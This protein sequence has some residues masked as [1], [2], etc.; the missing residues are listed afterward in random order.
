MEEALKATDYCCRKNHLY[1]RVKARQ[2]K[3]IETVKAGTRDVLQEIT[4]EA[5]ADEDEDV[6]SLSPSPSKNQQTQCRRSNRITT[7]ATEALTNKGM[8][9]TKNQRTRRLLEEAVAAGVKSYMT[10]TTTS[11]T[12]TSASRTQ[13][14]RTQKQAS[15]HRS[16]MKATKNDE[17]GCYKLALKEA[18]MIYL[19]GEKSFQLICNELN[20]KYN[21]HGK[22]KL[23]RMTLSTYVKAKK[24]NQS[25]LKRGPKA[26]LPKLF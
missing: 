6:S 10:E 12:T 1:K 13:P 4:I 15:Y 19:E 24:V 5:D 20:K 26:T 11:S 16:L 9:K 21:L 22:R 7:K 17:E 8:F 23:N 3:M 14:R 25:P 2:D 18:T